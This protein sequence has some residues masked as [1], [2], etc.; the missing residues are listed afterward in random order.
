LY[1]DSRKDGRSQRGALANNRAANAAAMVKAVH[2]GRTMLVRAYS[3]KTRRAAAATVKKPLTI[4][5]A[6]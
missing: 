4:P 6:F 2:L 3:V 5:A 1:L